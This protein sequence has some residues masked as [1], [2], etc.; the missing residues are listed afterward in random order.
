MNNLKIDRETIIVSDTHFKH[1][2]ITKFEPIRAEEMKKKGYETYE[3]LFDSKEYKI[4]RRIN[5]DKWLI[6]L[7]NENVKPNQ[8]VLHMGDF[9]F[10]LTFDNPELIKVFEA[11]APN[12]F[13]KKKLKKELEKLSPKELKDLYKIDITKVSS[14]KENKDIK[15]F[16]KIIL[17]YLPESEIFTR[18]SDVLNGNII[19]VLGNHDVKQSNNN[20]GDIKVIKGFYDLDKKIFDIKNDYLFSGFTKTMNNK[21]IMFCHYPL[22]D[23]DNEYPRKNKRL[24]TR[25]EKLEELYKSTN[26]E[27]VIHGHAH[28]NTCTFKDSYNTSIEV[29]RKIK[30]TSPLGF[31]KIGDI[32]DNI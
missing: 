2:N 13:S 6:E 24:N 17:D 10:G 20:Y 1:S 32:L 21:K 3:N 7:W 9:A 28:S 15:A 30:S 18:Y 27:Y 5:H 16:K 8:D 25:V 26:C 29:N 11:L 14:P 31:I 19:L 22:F 12:G 4:P 23:T